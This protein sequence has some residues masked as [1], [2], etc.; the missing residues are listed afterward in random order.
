V[1]A[2]AIIVTYNASRDLPACLDALAREGLEE[3]IVV[4]NASCDGSA[5]LAAARSSVRVIRSPGNLGFGGGC[6][7]GAAT[8]G[9]DVYIFMNPDVVVRRGATRALV[10]AAAASGGIVGP[11]VVAGDKGTFF[12]ARLDLL[13]APLD[14][15]S[16]DRPLF[17]Q[18]CALAIGRELFERIGGFDARYFLFAEDAELCLRALRAG[19]DVRVLGH[20]AVDH[21]GG[22]S[23]GG[24]Y[25]ANASWMISNRRFALRERNTLAMVL[26]NAPAAFAIWFVLAHVVKVGLLASWAGAT[27]RWTLARDLTSGLWWNVAELPASLRR[28]R[29]LVAAAGFSSELSRRVVALSALAITRRQGLPRFEPG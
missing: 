13:G 19:R 3:I 26:A 24:A 17:V 1:T 16:P 7:L 20:V 15:V 11:V 21:V 23:I 8:S 14:L 5:D 29:S 12:G 10:D 6:N 27:G 4:D 28:R 22:A 18:G 25:A 2:A 9:S